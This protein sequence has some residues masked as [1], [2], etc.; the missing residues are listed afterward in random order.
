MR[1]TEFKTEA[2]INSLF[3]AKNPIQ[4]PAVVTALYTDPWYGL[5]NETN[6]L[7]WQALY[8]TED[9]LV[10]L[11]FKSELRTYFSLSSA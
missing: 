6:Y 2:K 4:D 8:A 11:A 5:N 1:G 7:Q 9:P 10:R 3:V